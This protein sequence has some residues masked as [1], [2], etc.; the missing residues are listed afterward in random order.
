MFGN[1]T[2]GG[3]DLRNWALDLGSALADDETGVHVAHVAIGVWITG[4]APEGVASMTA[5]EI[6]PRYGELVSGRS[7]HELVIRE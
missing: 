2:P 3:A 6:A 4:Q 7:T 5:D 1:I